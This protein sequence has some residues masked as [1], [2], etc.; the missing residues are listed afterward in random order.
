MDWPTIAKMGAVYAAMGLVHIV[1][2]KRFLAMSFAPERMRHPH[3]WDFLFYVSFGV[4]ISFSVEIAGVLM[5]FSTLVIPAVIAFLF[6][7]RFGKALPIAWAAGTVA[8][9]AGTAASFVWD[10]AT[11]PLLVCSFGAVLVAAFALRAVLGVKTG[12]HVRVRGLEPVTE[13]VAAPA[14]T[15][16][17]LTAD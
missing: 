1:F 6:T 3:V 8:I 5:V 16:E 7:D 11:G 9:V 15:V 14:P 12:E 17:G 10:L 13:A 4:V 2:R